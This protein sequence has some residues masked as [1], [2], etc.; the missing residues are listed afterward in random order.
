MS[1]PFKVTHLYH[2]GVI[3]ETE[4]AQLFFD[5]ITD[6]RPFK[7]VT[8]TQYYFVTHAHDDHFKTDIFMH[9]GPQTFY[10]LS[11]DI[12]YVSDEIA[13]DHLIR[14]APNQSYQ[15]GELRIKTLDSTD[16]GVAFL[17]ETEEMKIFH[18][19]DLNWWHWESST[20]EAQ[21]IE[22]EQ[23]KSIL[24]SLAEERL[25][26][27]FVP[28][29]P[30]LEKSAH[31]AIKYFMAHVDSKLIFPIHFADAYAPLKAILEANNLLS[32]VQLITRRNESFN[33]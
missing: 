26:L 1:K 8:K 13:E 5:V 29:D 16:R 20:P 2:S 12:P 25:D 28:V 18:S 11:T 32:N 9:V 7:N 14:V 33:F 22:A 21:K 10:A 6:C 24:T 23:Y 3:V 31:Y 17:V 15:L 30:R 19:G 27:A 4:S